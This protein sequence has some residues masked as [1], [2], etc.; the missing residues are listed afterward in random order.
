VN[1]TSNELVERAVREHRERVQQAVE[2]GGLPTEAEIDAAETALTEAY[3]LVEAIAWRVA[4]IGEIENGDPDCVAYTVTSAQIG[5]V[6]AFASHVLDLEVP[7]LRDQAA[8]IRDAVG[9]LDT[10]RRN[11]A[12]RS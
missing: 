2:R 10:V 5:L 9:P 11:Q 4:G 7:Q 3:A 12:R 6:A 1:A 8:R